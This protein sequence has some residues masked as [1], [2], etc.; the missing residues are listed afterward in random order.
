MLTPNTLTNTPEY[1]YALG[2]VSDRWSDDDL[3]AF[4]SDNELAAGAVIARGVV[5]RPDASD[6]LPDADDIVNH[7]ANSANDE[8][9]EFCDGFPDVSDA[10][11]A[12]LE[13]ALGALK[14]WADKH[15]AVTFYQVVQ[16]DNYTVTAEDRTAADQYLSQQ[17]S[18]SA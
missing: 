18:Q 10:A 17:Q 4:V 7:M 13:V 11:T 14:A 12:E 15:C 9:S 6:F 5:V 1:S 2:T 3:A 8:H 16:I